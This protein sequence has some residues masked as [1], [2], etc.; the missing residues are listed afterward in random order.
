MDYNEVRVDVS[1]LAIGLYL[2]RGYIVKE[3][4]KIKVENESVLIYLVI[5]RQFK[6]NKEAC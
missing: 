2:R 4:H 5:E 3:N 6:R 1:L